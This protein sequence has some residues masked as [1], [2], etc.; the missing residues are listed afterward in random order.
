M[1]AKAMTLALKTDLAGYKKGDIRSAVSFAL[2]SAVAQAHQRFDHYAA[3]C[4]K[5]EKKYDITSDEFIRQFESGSM[6]DEQ[7]Y[8]DWYAARRGLDIWRGRYEILSGVSV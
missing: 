5:F 8:F 1:E 2:N 7:D 6:G 4:Q 3:I